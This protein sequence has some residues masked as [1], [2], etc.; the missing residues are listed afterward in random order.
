[1]SMQARLSKM[2]EDRARDAAETTRQQ[3]EALAAKGQL[4]QAL[5]QLRRQSDE[6]VL[7]ERQ[8]LAQTEERAKRY[9]LDGELARTLAGQP[10]VPGGADQLTQLWRGQFNVQPEG[11]SFAVRTPT[12]QS[13]G[14]FVAA[15]LGRPEFAHFLRAQNPSGGTGG[16]SP[17]TQVPHTHAATTTLEP[18]PRNLGE[19]IVRQMA[20]IAKN[21]AAN[22]HLSGGSHLSELGARVNEPA[23]GFGLRRSG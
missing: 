13:V 23:A 12:F 2:E 22:A 7:A 18:E 15:Q 14:E 19:A 1:M 6:A 4:E 5:Q 20:G 21:Q 8:K 10:L 9:A 11:D 16:A 17:A 3:S